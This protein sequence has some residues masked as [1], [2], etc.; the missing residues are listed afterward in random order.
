MRSIMGTPTDPT[1]YTQTHGYELL[2]QI[3]NWCYRNSWVSPFFRIHLNEQN[4]NKQA[5]DET[6][7]Y[8]QHAGA[9]CL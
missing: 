7:N 6:D 9:S 1:W 2:E 3:R 8:F 5:M 4:M